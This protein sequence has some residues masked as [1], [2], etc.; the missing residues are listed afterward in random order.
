MS[1]QYVAARTALAPHAERARAVYVV[2]GTECHVGSHEHAL[3]CEL[4]AV[5]HPDTGSYAAHRWD[6]DV[7]GTLCTFAHHMP[8]T[9]RKY[10]EGGAMSIVLGNMQLNRARLG[11]AVPRVASYAHRHVPG[12]Y[13]D[14]FAACVVSPCWQIKTSHGEK[15]ATDSVPVIG[16]AVWEIKE[17]GGLPVWHYG[18]QYKPAEP[19]RVKA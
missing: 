18:W 6:I 13:T 3:G 9:S 11:Q 16:G 1:P 15:V 14:G 7:N 10:L 4:G 19:G 8:T 5:R 2:V 12:F 17:P